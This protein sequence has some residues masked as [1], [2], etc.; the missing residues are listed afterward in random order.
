MSADLLCALDP[1]F[2]PLLARC[3]PCVLPLREREPYEALVAAVAGQQLH[4][5]AATA[6]LDRFKQLHPSVPFPTPDMLLATDDA[7]LRA[8]GFSAAKK[9]A[10][11]AVATAALN[12]VVPSRAEADALDDAALIARLIPLRGV[13][14]W[15]VEMLLIFTLGRPDVL[16]TDDWAVREGW[17]RVTGQAAQLKPRALGEI[18]QRWA[19]YRTTAAWYLWRVSEEAK[20]KAA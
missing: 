15:T 13:G 10:L 1:V 5:R 16:P 9:A 19:P 8:C 20:R 12:G 17:R 6:I 7:A 18:G 11:R 2:V 4:A 3:A 14:R